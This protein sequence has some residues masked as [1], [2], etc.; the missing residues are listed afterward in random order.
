MIVFVNAI[1]RGCSDWVFM[2]TVPAGSECVGSTIKTGKYDAW[3]LSEAM[4]LVGVSDGIVF[5]EVNKWTQPLLVHMENNS[6]H[7]NNEGMQCKD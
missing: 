3:L 4:M 1:V 7:R 5:D 2:T 6:R